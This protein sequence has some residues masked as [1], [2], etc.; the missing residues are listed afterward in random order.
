MITLVAS[1]V[2]P[3]QSVI[4]LVA[5]GGIPITISDYSRCISLCF[6]SAIMT[7]KCFICGLGLNI[8]FSNHVQYSNTASCQETECRVRSGRC[9]SNKRLSLNVI[10]CLYFRSFM[11]FIEIIYVELSHEVRHV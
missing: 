7:N 6:Q 5:S 11:C 2:Y 8:L 10:C 1:G 3:S 4:T 9:V